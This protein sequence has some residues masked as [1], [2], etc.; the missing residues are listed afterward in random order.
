MGRE[1]VE[2]GLS[3]GGAGAP[4]AA[5]GE[6]LAALQ[7]AGFRCLLAALHAATAACLRPACMCAAASYCCDCTMPSTLDLTS[8]LP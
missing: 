7:P 6:Q 5:L 8:C 3:T 2:R 4:G 1:V